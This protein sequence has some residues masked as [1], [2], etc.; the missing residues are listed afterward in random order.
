V[1]FVHKTPLHCAT[2][3]TNTPSPD[4]QQSQ[5]KTA[6]QHNERIGEEKRSLISHYWVKMEK[7]VKQGCVLSPELFSLYTESIMNSIAH[8][9]GIKIGGNDINNLSYANDTVIIAD[10]EDQL[11]NIMDIVTIESKIAGLEINQNK[12]FTQVISKK[13][14]I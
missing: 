5:F 7:G 9:E 8:M 4:S 12:S 13:K 6:F 10:T 3:R 2:P 1:T 14:E 11:Q